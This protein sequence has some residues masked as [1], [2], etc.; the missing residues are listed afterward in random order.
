MWGIHAAFLV[1]NVLSFSLIS[2]NTYMRLSRTIILH[3][4]WFHDYLSKR[5][6]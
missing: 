3:A 5:I 4:V 1:G 2:K 6:C